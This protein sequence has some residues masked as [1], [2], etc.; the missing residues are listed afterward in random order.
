[1]AIFLCRRLYANTM[2][3]LLEEPLLW[4]YHS[5]TVNLIFGMILFF[6]P[7]E[8]VFSVLFVMSWDVCSLVGVQKPTPAIQ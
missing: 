1:M 3:A 6:H 5:L 4:G 7:G 2:K 8:V